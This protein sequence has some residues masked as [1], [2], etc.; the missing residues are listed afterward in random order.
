M[1]TCHCCLLFCLVMYFVKHSLLLGRLWRKGRSS[2]TTSGTSCASNS[3]REIG[4]GMP[5]D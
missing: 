2:I 4:V 1:F 3:A 5:S